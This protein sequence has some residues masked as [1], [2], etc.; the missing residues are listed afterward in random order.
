MAINVSLEIGKL[1]DGNRISFMSTAYLM[2]IKTTQIKALLSIWNIR[3]FAR[4]IAMFWC[5]HTRD[6]S[7]L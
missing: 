2:I 7:C 4:N 5:R 1:T 3:G 6:R